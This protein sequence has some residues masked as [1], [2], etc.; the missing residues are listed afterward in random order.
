M[1]ILYV[2]PVFG[3]SGDMMISAL[4]DAGLPFGELEHLFKKIPLPLPVIRPVKR[5]QG[6]INGTGLDIESSSIYLSI[7]EMEEIIEKID[8]SE[9]VKKDARAILLTVS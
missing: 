2:D 5:A 3:L 7:R 6:I 4:I 8:E 9:R 1:N